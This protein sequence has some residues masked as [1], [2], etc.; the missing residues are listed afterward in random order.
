MTVCSDKFTRKM[1][2]TLSRN[3]RSVPGTRIRKWMGQPPSR[4]RSKQERALASSLPAK[5][6]ARLLAFVFNLISDMPQ[7]R[8]DQKRAGQRSSLDC[9][10]AV[11]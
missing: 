4:T 11:R 2:S 7:G 8:S 5:V 10:S 6:H 3:D 9:V 1:L